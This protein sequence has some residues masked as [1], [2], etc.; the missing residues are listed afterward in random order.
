M[1]YYKI[2]VPQFPSHVIS[3]YRKTKPNIYEKINY[4]KIFSGNLFHIKRNIMI[5]E[6]H[7][8]I[9]PFI[10][11]NLTI[12]LPIIVN[13]HMIAPL[14]WGS[15]Q[16][17]NGNI[18]WHP[19]K[20]NYNPNWDCF[21]AVDVWRKVIEDVLTAHN[22]YP[23]DNVRYLRGGGGY[24]PEFCDHIDDRKLVIELISI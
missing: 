14:N 17:R 18:V 8:F 2:E 6:M 4:N 12:K 24:T 1:N 3:Q 23:D 22:I 19:A 7:K 15:V 5:T 11:Y 10:P 20:P 9:D 21:N 16:R 13:V